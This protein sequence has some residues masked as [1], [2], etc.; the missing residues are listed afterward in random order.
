MLYVPELRKKLFSVESDVTTSKMKV[1]I[2]DNNKKLSNQCYTMFF[3]L[4]K[5]E[6]IN[7]SLE[8]DPIML[9]WHKRLGDINCYTLKLLAD[10][11]KRPR[12]EI[13]NPNNFQ[14]DIDQFENK[15][16][17]LIY[18]FKRKAIWAL[19]IWRS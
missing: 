6:Q 15:Y 9:Y 3:K 5:R 8:V 1:I 17:A 12:L 4:V 18:L 10:N 2:F 19:V 11:G 14:F 7:V 13:K 16:K